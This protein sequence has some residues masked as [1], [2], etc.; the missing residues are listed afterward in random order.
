MSS[1]T[2]LL[3]RWRSEPSIGGNVTKWHEQ[4]ARPG[5][6]APLPK[7]ADPRLAAAFHLL[8]FEQLYS[9]Q[10]AAWDVL[11]A[12]GNVAVVAGT[13]SG[14][15][16]CYNLPVL[17][18]ALK[19]PEA[20]ALYLFPTKALAYDQQNGLKEWLSALG[21]GPEL[22]SAVYDGDTRASDRPQI[23]K[24]SR[25]IL[26][27]PDML[28]IGILP[29]HT[30]WAEFFAQ[31]RYVVLDE[32]HSYR[33]LF[34]SN[35]A[36]VLRRLDRICAFYGAAPQ[37]ILASATISNPKELAEKLV[38]QPV[39][40]VDEDGAPHGP[41]SF[42]IYNPPIVNQDLGLRASVSQEAVQLASDLL[43]H[44]VQTIL[45]GRTRRNIEIMLTNLRA[46]SGGEPEQIR[47]YRSGYLVRERREIEEGLRSGAVRGVVSTTALELGVDIGGLDAAVLA[48]YPGTVAATRQQ[49]G[50]AGRKDGAA[51]V[52]LLLYSNPLEQFLARHPHYLLERSPEQALVNPNNLKI[53]H[54]HLR[55]AAYEL[56]F[57]QGEAFGSV[58]AEEVEELLQVLAQAG[59]VHES[60]G[61]YFWMSEGYP[62][63][64]VSLRGSGE[65]S[66]ALQSYEDAA[67]K[68]IGEVDP[69]GAHSLVHPE[70]IYIHEGRTYFVDEL[71][72]DE[73]IAKMHPVEVD[74][75]TFPVHRTTIEVQEKLEEGPARGGIRNYG[76]LLITDQVHRYEKVHWNLNEMPGG[77]DLDLPPVNLY[78]V[79]YWFAF[80]EAT[81][82]ILRARGE[83]RSDPNDYGP[84]WDAIKQRAR[85]RDDYICQACGAPEDGRAHDVHHRQPFRLFGTPA[86]ANRLENLVTLC[87]TCHHQ[88][89]NMVRVRTG[90][91][92]L[93]FVLSHLAPLYL[94]CDPHDFGV[95]SDPKSDMAEGVPVIAIYDNTP[96]GIGLSRRLYEIHDELMLQAYELVSACDCA[97]GCPACVGPG[98]EQGQGSKK[99]T[100]AIL[101]A[102]TG[103][104]Q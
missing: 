22:V 66:V 24:R 16:L 52:V 92:G 11:Q 19:D 69:V 94:M 14:K 27:N 8:G 13:A 84:N 2:S 25:L 55:C 68:L 39:E 33:G 10:R 63:L 34:G 47:G 45:F 67:W 104:A 49:A 9:H 31:L 72:L 75:Y 90:L 42:L 29:Y 60:G 80:D 15:T 64:G 35:V 56:P 18:A 73:N 1:L 12:G 36:N 77:G 96:D 103:S 91:G 97:D 71:N 100:L 26:S 51:L 61:K 87:P 93:A 54:A 89:E 99:E 65:G 40:L 98:G 95:H 79:G 58:G 70:A 59:Q 37:F 41:R 85:E 20:R 38:D 32:M 88:A 17:D 78:T 3:A 101:K 50:R 5:A 74:Y 48:G 83:W 23:R 43:T 30:R 44:D 28:H 76:R 86:E 6:F 53:L 82:N 46:A 57:R 7:G 102:L 81:A 4:P 62:A 21:A